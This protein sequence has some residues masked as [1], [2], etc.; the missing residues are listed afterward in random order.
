MQQM[1]VMWA[2]ASCQLN[3]AQVFSQMVG[4]QKLCQNMCNTSTSIYGN[5]HTRTQR[6]ILVAIKALH[7]QTLL[8]YSSTSINMETLLLWG[9]KYELS[10]D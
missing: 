4:V 10:S 2:V 6:I 7:T 1:F 8:P 9:I 3:E 5:T